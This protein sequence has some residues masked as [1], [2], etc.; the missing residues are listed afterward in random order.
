MCDSGEEGIHV[1]KHIFF[2]RRFLLVMRSIGHHEGFYCFP[3][4]EEI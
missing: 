4:Y 1:V 3:S 2:C